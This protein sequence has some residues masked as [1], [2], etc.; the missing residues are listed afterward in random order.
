MP[1]DIVNALPAQTWRHFVQ[2]QPNSNIFH[3]SEMFQ[4]VAQTPGYTP[5]LWAATGSDSQVLALL[6]PVRITLSPLLGKLTTRAVSYGS[7]LYEPGPEG[8]SALR[9]LLDAYRQHVGRSCLFSELRNISDLAEAQPVLQAC[10]FAYEEYLNYLIDLARPPQVILQSFGSR[11]RKQIRHGL[12]LGAVKVH[13]VT[14]AA[15]LD[16]WYSVLGKT[17]QR[18]G[19]PLPPR[20]LFSAS[21]QTLVPKNMAR[22]TT[23]SVDGQTAACS[24]ELLFKDTVYGW[25]G[26]MDRQLSKHLPTE[27]L[28]WHILCWGT[29]NGY[30]FYDFGGAGQPGV[31]YG[32]RDFK[33][34]F[35]GDLVCYGRNTCVHR[36]IQLWLAKMGYSISRKWNVLT[37][38][39]HQKR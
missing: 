27:L 9:L 2:T 8:L 37:H 16:Q 17:Y 33:A 14:S 12:R 39:R 5:T 34:K 23:A 13:E 36:P 19:V 1:I 21:L 6:V 29:E 3:T 28:M 20:A 35:G 30:R 22:F 26:G 11:T 31:E 7:I 25:Y 24:L 15:D 10:G 38:Q 4:V 18:A 32:V